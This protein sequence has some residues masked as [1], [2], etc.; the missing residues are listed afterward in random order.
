MFKTI[1]RCARTVARHENGP[2]AQSR[3]KYLEHL[4]AGG[5]CV[6]S[7]RVHAGVIYRTAVW[8]NLDDTSPVER[9]AVE[10]AAKEWAN[11]RYRNASAYGPEQTEKE[12]KFITCS[13]LR[14]TGRLRESDLPPIPH[15]SALDAY[16]RHMEQERGLAVATV[17]SSRAQ[18]IKF[19]KYTEGRTLKQLRIADVE[20]F[21]ASLGERGW[22]R[23]GICGMAHTIRGFFKYT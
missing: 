18:L 22:T 7:L 23:A 21:L 5:A 17:V 6:H 20:R 2:A 3:L 8:M 9:T 12:F 14:Y 16:Y 13:W 1:Y 10:K 4:A 15:Q 19:L 11:R